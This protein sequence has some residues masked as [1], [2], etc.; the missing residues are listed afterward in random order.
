MSFMALDNSMDSGMVTVTVSS[1]LDL[2]F[3]FWLFW[4]LGL[5]PLLP[6]SLF[7]VGLVDYLAG[8]LAS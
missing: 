7:M 6:L 1:S 5:G 8:W 4:F 2:T 3:F